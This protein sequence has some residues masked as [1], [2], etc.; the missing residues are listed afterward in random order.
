MNYNAIEELKK[1][2]DYYPNSDLKST[3]RKHRDEIIKLQTAIETVWQN[4]Q[5]DKNEFEI[6]YNGLR[7]SWFV[8]YY[9]VLGEQINKM[10]GEI[11]GIEKLIYLGIQDKKWQTRFNTVV[12][13][14]AFNNQD[15]KTKIIFTYNKEI[16]I[17]IVTKEIHLTCPSKMDM[18]III[19][20]ILNW[21]LL[22]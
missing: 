12:I 20:N 1:Y 13:M 17:P 11:N 10:F 21:E 9:Y 19:K 7:N 14:K 5:L 3:Y 18:E 15:V 4:Q 2:D 8:V 16:K 6:L 22:I